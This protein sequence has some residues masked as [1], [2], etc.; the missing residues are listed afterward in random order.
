MRM[1][2]RSRLKEETRAAHL[3]VEALVDAPRSFAS[4]AAYAS[5][6]RRSFGARAGM[7]RACRLALPAASE[8]WDAFFIEPAMSRDLDELGIE[9][10]D[11]SGAPLVLLDPAA[12]TGALYVLAGSAL[13]ATTL[14]SGAQALGL[15]AS[16]A[17]RHL[18]A[19]RA[20]A[21]GF[22]AFV[23]WLDGL[24]F[25]SAQSGRCVQ[26]AIAAFEAMGAPFAKRAETLAS[27]V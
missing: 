26:G 16:V 15:T 24:D 14:V 1:G 13:G 4:V 3:A 19:Q 9:R 27:D 2:L 18:F 20:A 6:V 11:V 21:R 17:A 25:D 23:A 5:Y 10:P 8:R 22:A 12:A 7:E